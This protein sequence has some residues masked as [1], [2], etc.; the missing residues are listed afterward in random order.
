MTLRYITP[1]ESETSASG[2]YS[3]GGQ[4]RDSRYLAM[5]GICQFH[6]SA[7]VMSG[8]F[9]SDHFSRQAREAAEPAPGAAAKKRRRRRIRLARRIV[10]SAALALVVLAGALVGGS[11][12]F[13]N[14]LASSF[15]RIHG[16]A[17][18]TAAD[19]PAVPAKFRGSMTIV[20]TGSGLAN[21]GP[22]QSRARSGLISLIHLNAD[23]RAGAVINIPAD[24]IVRIP[25]HGFRELWA[26]LPLGGPS[27]LIR[28]LEQLTHAR[29]Q[30][31]SAL[32]VG[33]V[34]PV[35]RALGGVK[36]V[37]PYTTTSMG[38]TFRKGVNT[39]DAANVLA[40][41]RQ[42]GVSEIG[43]GL[44]QQNL[45]RAILSKLAQ[46]S[47]LFYFYRVVRTMARVLSV[48]SS[49]SNSQLMSLAL[50]LRHLHGRDGTFVTAPTLRGSPRYGGTRAVHL[51]RRLTARLWRALR[52][53]S[54]AAFARRYPFTVTPIDPG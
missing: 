36:V 39:L 8:Q 20:L 6:G 50:Q 35:I 34:A 53:D 21:A 40:Y 44:L 41:V 31:Y 29:I 4:G 38:F 37:V 12:L 25:G 13:I 46:R 24:A 26:A 15:H 48:D 10:L 49:L 1:H 14:H 9:T 33:G 3:P 51:N 5:A 2:E 52:T 27:L 54:V 17:A 7:V 22:T 43:R 45:I 32:N 18:L 23:H 28:T 47:G 30:H 42:P 11:Y 19:Q 16:I